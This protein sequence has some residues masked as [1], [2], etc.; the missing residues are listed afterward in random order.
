MCLGIFGGL[1]ISVLEKK[2]YSQNKTMIRLLIRISCHFE[3]TSELILYFSKE[4]TSGLIVIKIDWKK[5]RR[6][7]WWS[8]I[9]MYL[10]HNK[11]LF[12]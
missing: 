10:Y 6:Y 5:I 12:F 3:E 9:L 8:K 11:E 2:V 1:L 7:T 4:Y